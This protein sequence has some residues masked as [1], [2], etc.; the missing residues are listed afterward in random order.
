VCGGGELFEWNRLIRCRGEQQLVSISLFLFSS[1]PV[2][3]VYSC[4]RLWDARRG[5]VTVTFSARTTFG[6][7]RR[8]VRTGVVHVRCSFFFRSS[9]P[10]SALRH[11]VVKTVSLSANTDSARTGILDAV[12]PLRGTRIIPLESTPNRPEGFYPRDFRKT[13]NPT[14]TSP[15]YRRF[16]ITPK[17]RFICTPE[18]TAFVL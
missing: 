11:I 4:L 17:T 14:R 1:A 7:D 15:P 13:K 6:H 18:T 12:F 9:R 2:L 3:R 8:P 16:R 5:P 10:G